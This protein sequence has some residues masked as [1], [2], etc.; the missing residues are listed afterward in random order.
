M[1]IKI[2]GEI[3]PD[4]LIEILSKVAAAYGE[5]FG[6]FFGANL[7]INAFDKDGEPLDLAD[8]EGNEPM[9][10]FGVPD[11]EMAR[12]LL[13]DEAKSHLASSELTRSAPAGNR[14]HGTTRRSGCRIT[15]SPRAN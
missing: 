7:Y 14:M 12:P 2:S 10:S 4:R 3:R 11:G 1:R 15:Y 9:F 8:F 13:S 5:N 6:G